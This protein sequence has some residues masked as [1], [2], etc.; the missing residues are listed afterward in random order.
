M[1]SWSLYHWIFYPWVLISASHSFM[2]FFKELWAQNWSLENITR[3]TLRLFE[4][5]QG[6]SRFRD[7]LMLFLASLGFFNGSRLWCW[8]KCCTERYGQGIHTI[9]LPL[10]PYR[11]NH[12]IPQR[13]KNVLCFLKIC[14]P[15]AIWPYSGVS[16]R[17]FRLIQGVYYLIVPLLINHESLKQGSHC[18]T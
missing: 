15:A 5:C 12:L 18:F 11:M 9:K 13:M 17:S 3:K 16:I 14:H 10:F 2:T 7:V 8:L 4:S 6:W 1:L